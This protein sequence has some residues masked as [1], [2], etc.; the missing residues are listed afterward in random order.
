[1]TAS[2][3]TGELPVVTP[4]PE[5]EGPLIPSPTEPPAWFASLVPPKD[6]LPL[7]FDP[8]ASPP[9]A[10]VGAAID[11][12]A[13]ETGPAL[14]VVT[15]PAESAA[16][17]ARA[18]TA[19]ASPPAPSLP[20]PS[21][22]PPRLV[23][24]GAQATAASTATSTAASTAPAPAPAPA[25]ATA[26]ATATAT[27]P[28]LVE[29]LRGTWV[30]GLPTGLTV[31]L[32]AVLMTPGVLLD[33]AR[34]GSFGLPS[35]VLLLLVAGGAPLVLRPRSLASGIVLPPLVFAATAAAIAWRSG[36]NQ[37]SRQIGLDAGTTLALHAPVAFAAT[38]VAV[39][40]VLGRVA[41]RL[42]RR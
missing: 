3:D 37:G 35:T 28:S 23:V 34:D 39:L 17:T 27:T 22:V 1:V 24:P 13:V 2:P 19:T 15:G 32:V 11:M 31:L 7:D 20:Q 5:T 26:T 30:Q 40:V 14:V 38:A 8:L 4:A 9:A 10:T 29:R 21:E 16:A 41:V 33:V 6:S 25:P 36:L 42:V 18:E 12:V